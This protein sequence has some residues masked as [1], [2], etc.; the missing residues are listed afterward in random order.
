[1]KISGEDYQRLE[2]AIQ[3]VLVKNRSTLAG[4][5]DRYQYNGLSHER[6]R[7]DLFH[8]AKLG[9]ALYNAGLNDNHIDTALR[10]ITHA[11]DCEPGE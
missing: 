9:N 2:A 8:A 11:A 10:R 7:W 6:M 5:W 3:D 1:M 4:V